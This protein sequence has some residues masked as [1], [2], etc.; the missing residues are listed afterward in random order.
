M[1]ASPL[2][3]KTTVLR[4]VR[5]TDAEFILSLRLDPDIGRHLSKTDPDVDLQ[6]AW[7]TRYGDRE[8]AGT[9]YYYIIENPADHAIGTVR[10]YDFQGPSFAWGSWI[11]KRGSPLLVAIGSALRVYDFAFYDLGFTEAHLEVRRENRTAFAFHRRFGAEI[12]HSDDIDHFLRITRDSYES[13]RPRYARAIGA[14]TPD[15]WPLSQP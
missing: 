11:I 10:I 4:P 6:R 5:P 1:P 13:V 3:C 15:S 9:E 7:I 2:Y 14:T 8:E 12:T